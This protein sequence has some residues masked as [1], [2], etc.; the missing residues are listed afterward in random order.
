[1]C[2][3]TDPLPFMKAL[4]CCYPMDKEIP[5]YTVVSLFHRIMVP[6]WLLQLQTLSS[7]VGL[8]S[9][10]RHSSPGPP[11]SLGLCQLC[12]LLSKD[13]EYSISCRQWNNQGINGGDKF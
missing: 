7:N 10:S 3:Q 9:S 13:A 8:V 4:I 1:M 6:L 12:P 11:A 5:L 2:V